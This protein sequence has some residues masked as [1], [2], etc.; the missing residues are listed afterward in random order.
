[1]DGFVHGSART[2][3]QDRTADIY[4]HGVHVSSSLL[5]YS[6][7]FIFLTAGIIR[8]T[9]EDFAPWNML[10]KAVNLA[11]AAEQNNTMSSLSSSSGQ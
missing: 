11:A 8:Y 9:M 3:R 5:R 6:S 7:P 10:L 4:S 1:M 2:E